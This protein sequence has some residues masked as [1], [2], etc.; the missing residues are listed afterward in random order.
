MPIG[1]CAGAQVVAAQRKKKRE[2]KKAGAPKGGAQQSKAAADSAGGAKVFDSAGAASEHLRALSLSDGSLPI[3][4]TDEDAALLAEL[5]ES[6][7]TSEEAVSP[8]ARGAPADPWATEAAPPQPAAPVGQL[9]GELFGAAPRQYDD[10]A[11]AETGPNPFADVGPAGVTSGVRVADAVAG[12]FPR[13]SPSAAP[14][15]HDPFGDA[16]PPAGL[17]DEVPLPPPPGEGN[18]F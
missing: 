3:G 17:V 1:R 15:T 16:A 8:D 12:R 18:P 4:L 7:A 9:L 6:F 13:P 2:A 10:E 5:R 11:C 14:P